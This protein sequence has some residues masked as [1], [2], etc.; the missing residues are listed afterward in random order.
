MGHD[1]DGEA[2]LEFV[3]RFLDLQSG[4]RIQS[5]TR[6]IHQDH[7][8]LDG[9]RACNAEA[10]LLTTREGI[11]TFI[12]LVLAFVPDSGLAQGPFHEFIHVTGETVDPGTESNVLVDALGERVGLLEHHPDPTAHFNRVN[13]GTVKIDTV[14]QNT[15]LEGT[16]LDQIVHAVEGTQ[17][18]RLTAA[19]WTDE[20]GDFSAWN[21]AVDV[22]HGFVAA[23]TDGDVL[24]R[25]RGVVR[26]LMLFSLK[27]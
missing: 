2:L 10:L 19:G 5:R 24:D 20:G 1:H 4:D 21:I 27:L 16:S 15:T 6:F 23:V 18:R 3:H 11:T 22:L 26:D 13:T 7:F 14:E 12:Q 25:D 17:H 8:R 9:D